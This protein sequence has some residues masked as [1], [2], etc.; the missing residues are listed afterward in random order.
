MYTDRITCLSSRSNLKLSKDFFKSS[1]SSNTQGFTTRKWSYRYGS[2]LLLVTFQS[3]YRTSIEEGLI[4][5]GIGTVCQCFGG[6]LRL[7]YPST[8]GSCQIQMSNFLDTHDY[9]LP[10]RKNFE[11]SFSSMSAFFNMRINAQGKEKKTKRCM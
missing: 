2:V 1:S 5:D 4:D 3:H 8:K 10:S 7:A 6:C 11:T 9:H